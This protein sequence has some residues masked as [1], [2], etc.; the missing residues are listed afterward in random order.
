MEAYLGERYGFRKTESDEQ[1]VSTWKDVFPQD[2]EKILLEVERDA[3]MVSEETGVK[4]SCLETFTGSFLGARLI[5]MF[6]G[7]IT[8]RKDVV[9]LDGTI[10]NIHCV[11][12]TMIKFMSESGYAIT[13]LVDGLTIDLGLKIGSR[14]WAFHR[15]IE[16]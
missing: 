2:R 1:A 14:Q 9:R 7:T 6:C 5:V 4:Y 10:Y 11:E 3:P 8:R 16:G 12:Y 13:N 15:H